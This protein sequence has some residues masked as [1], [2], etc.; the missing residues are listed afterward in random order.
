[1]ELRLPPKA[2][3]ARTP[4]PLERLEYI[5]PGLEN[6][7]IH[8]KREDLTGSILQGNK[9]RKLEY[10]LPDCHAHGA[11]T[12]I[13]CGGLQS[14]HCRAVACLAA[15][16]GLNAYLL[17]RGEKPTMPQANYLLDKL[18]GAQIE[19]ITAAD[20]LHVDEIMAERARKMESEGLKPYVIPEGGSNALGMCGYF[21]CDYNRQAK[22]K[23]RC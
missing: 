17:L 21:D 22:Q 7:E 11:D 2:N 12:L 6:F 10:F 23:A 14:N 3:I 1:M 18:V 16:K 8:L 20:Y 19:F 9:I 15:M 4:T 5:A 13:T